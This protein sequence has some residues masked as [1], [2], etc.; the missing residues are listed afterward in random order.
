MPNVGGAEN[1][2]EPTTESQVTDTGD[3]GASPDEPIAIQTPMGR[4]GASKDAYKNTSP[5]DI[6]GYANREFAASNLQ[7]DMLSPAKGGAGKKD[8]A[9]SE[10]FSSESV[11][12]IFRQTKFALDQKLENNKLWAQKL[13]DEVSS[14]SKTL[15]KVHTDYAH[16]Q[17]QE[18]QEAQRLDHLE[19]D[20]QGATIP[21]LD[22]ASSSIDSSGYD[23]FHNGVGKEASSGSKRTFSQE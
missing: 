19:P 13:L 15:S 4:P 11:D 12:A 5:T 7:D 23:T 1:D 6:I 16:T 22:S 21:M 20:V 17:S 8:S 10:I 3:H 14:Y 9:A 2:S 18:H